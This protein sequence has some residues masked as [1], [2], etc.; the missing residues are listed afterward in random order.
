MFWN[1]FWYV[2]SSQ[3]KRLNVTEGPGLVMQLGT[4]P[5]SELWGLGRWGGRGECGH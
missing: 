3:E 2:Q 1:V 4:A 5:P